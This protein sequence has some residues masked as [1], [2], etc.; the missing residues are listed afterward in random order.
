M[1]RVRIK[2]TISEGGNVFAGKTDSIPLEFIQPTL[3]KYYEELDRLFPQHSDKFRNFQPLGSVGK[4]ASSGDIDLAVNV[5]D[6]FPDGEVNPEDLESWGLSADEWKESLGKLSK[7]ARTSTQ[8]ELGWK[9]FLQ[10][11]AQ[12]ISKNSNLIVADLKKIGPGTMFSLFPQFNAKGEQQDIGV[13]IDWMVGNLDWLTFSYFS[14]A[15]S[16]EEPLLKGLHRTQ[17]IHALI[18]A[19]D[20]SFSHTAGVKNKET[21][22]LVAFSKQEILD[23]LSRLYRNTIT[24]N[25][26]QNFNTLYDWMR[27]IDEADRNRAL[28]AYLKI[29]DTT[30][31]NKDLDG[32]RCGYI[33]KVL[34]QTYLSLLNSGQMSGKFLCQKA[35]PTL[36]AA[37]NGS[38]KESLNNEE[39]ITVVIPGGFK[40]PHRGHVEMIN[41]FANL[42][43]VEQVIVFTGSKPRQSADGSIV[44]TAEKA[45]KLFNL[46]NLAPNVVFGNVKDRPKKDGSTFQNPFSDAVDVLFDENFRG[47]NVAIGHP[48]KDPS[49]ADQFAA[50]ASRTKSPMLANLVK[51]TPADTTD[52]LSATDLRNAVQNN[53]LEKLKDF[54]PPEIAEKYIQILIKK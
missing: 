12:Y 13:Q 37:K 29:L 23:L 3:D 20:H 35:N 42:P 21:D 41:H 9:A 34:E 40:P 14:D 33:P 31:G 38:I 45:K 22:E 17:L 43:N 27:N 7:R 32:E 18:L 6:L 36:W 2:K 4:K 11:L 16:E 39:K 53:D 28:R 48:T 30:R 15:P 51:V 50:R 49:Y 5:H 24:L 1:I 10:L 44:V 47:K 8:S 25:D 52:G 54:V 19:K 26:T 46:F